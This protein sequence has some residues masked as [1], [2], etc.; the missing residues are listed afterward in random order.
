M[1]ERMTPEALSF[2]HEREQAMLQL[3]T[4]MFEQMPDLEV[5]GQPDRL[6]SS[7]INGIK[8]MPVRLTG[9]A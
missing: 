9:S 7:F 1:A 8:R 6:K 4:G 5:A 3:L 2:L